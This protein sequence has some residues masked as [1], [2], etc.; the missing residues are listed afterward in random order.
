MGHQQAE[1][2]ALQDARKSLLTALRYDPDHVPALRVLAGVTF[3]LGEITATR[4]L[5]SRAL[6]L[7][8]SDPDLLF[9]KGN[10]ALQE[11]DALTALAA[12]H[13]AEEMGCESPELHYN[14][15][16]AHLFLG[17]AIQADAIFSA[18]VEAHPT[19]QRAWD[20]LG[21]ARRLKRDHHGAMTAFLR[22][23]Q[24]DAGLNEARDH[25]G[26][27]L[28][29]T[30]NARHAIQVLEAALQLDSLR[31]SSRHLLAMAHAMVQ[32]Y[33]EAVRHWEELLARAEMPNEGLHMLAN[34]YLH[35]E[36]KLK[37]RQTLEQLLD[38]EPEQAGAH[39]QLGLILL[40]S[41]EQAAGWRHLDVAQALDPQN[42]ALQSA[43][44]AALAYAPRPAAG[45]GE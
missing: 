23:L 40:E 20:G 8:P 19:H 35:V 41:G 12:Y 25:L 1:S 42:P 5:L 44:T 6:T 9:L 38:R 29:E 30:G 18:L 24:I 7:E 4:Q 13:Q 27:L 33:P 45:A 21:C 16:L 14:C 3:S 10:L 37:A 11:G 34:A 43:L 28:L 31:V 26:Q 36:N 32:E 22:A 39:I 15:G 17:D 2:G